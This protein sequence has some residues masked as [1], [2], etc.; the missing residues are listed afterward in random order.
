MEISG[1]TRLF[2]ILAD[3]ILQVKTPQAINALMQARGVNGVMVPLHVGASALCACF[4]ALRHVQNLDGFIVTVPHKQAAA[5]LCDEVSPAARAVGAVNVV[6]RESSGRL[7][8]DI[9]DGRGFVVGLRAHGI[10]PTGLRVFLAGAGGAANAIAFALADAGVAD[11]GIH[12][13]TPAKVHDMVDRLRVSHP[14]LTVA[15]VGHDPTGFDL[16]VN[17]TS[18]GMTTDDPLPFAAHALSATQTVAE[19]IMR[20]ALTP[21]LA[22]AQSRGCRI[23]FGAPMLEGQVDLMA[24]FMGISDAG[25][26]PV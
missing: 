16:V 9:L 21:M 3:P 6:R 14:G 13:R 25:R 5:S 20:P 18:L 24:R 8:G 7:V 12:N 17:A 22:I 11:L 10:E 2:A 26:E 4:D 15:A 19:I 23:Q 1:S